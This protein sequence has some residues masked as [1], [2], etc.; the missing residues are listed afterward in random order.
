MIFAEFRKFSLL[1]R[2][3]VAIVL[4]EKNFTADVTVNA[5]TLWLWFFF[6][7]FLDTNGGTSSAV[8]LRV[9]IQGMEKE[10]LQQWQSPQKWW[11]SEEEI[12]V[13]DQT[14]KT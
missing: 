10:T 12:Q 9:G 4:M 13:E 11:K 6:F 3:V 8:S 7:F 14:N 5:N 2:G 1:W